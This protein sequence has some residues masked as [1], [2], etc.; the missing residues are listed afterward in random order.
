MFVGYVQRVEV[1]RAQNNHSPPL[2][3]VV[4]LLPQ[5]MGM[6]VELDVLVWGKVHF[7]F[8]CTAWTIY[9]YDLLNI[10]VAVIATFF[11]LII[12][13]PNVRE[14]HMNIYW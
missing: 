4:E 10:F 9:C 6:D 11:I 12:K 14:Y 8:I 7:F 3:E 13:I 2:L 5:N 1:H